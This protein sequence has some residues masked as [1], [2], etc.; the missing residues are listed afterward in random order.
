MSDFEISEDGINLIKEFEGLR[1]QAYKDIV[2]VPT[3][4]YGST[5]GV[6]MGMII[7]EDQAIDLLR[8][9][10]NKF[11]AAVNRL[12]ENE[13]LTQPMFDALVSFCY[14]LGEGNLGKSTLLK[15]VNAGE[16][17]A[18]ADEFLKWN[19]AGGKEVRGLTRRREAERNL[20]RSGF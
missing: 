15:R 14:N 16:F 7:T 2:G 13:N 19:R 1:L 9:D 18:A 8:R 4:G 11:V 12:V 6:K 20:F 17:E 3:I 10:L 5:K